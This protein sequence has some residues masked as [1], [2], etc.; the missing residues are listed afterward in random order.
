M[1][2]IKN[3]T[4]EENKKGFTRKYLRLRTLIILV[5]LLV[6][7]SYAWFIFATK[8]SGGLT[9]HVTSWNVTFQVGEDETITNVII[10][11]STIYPGME[12]YVK[13]IKVKNV[14]ESTA[15]LSYQYKSL[16]ILG[17]TYTVGENCTEEELNEK[18]ANEYPFKINVTVDKNEL[19]IA[20]GEGLYT[21]TVEWPY[22]SGDDETDTYWGEKAYEFSQNN[23][24]KSSLQ[25]SLFLIAEQK[26]SDNQ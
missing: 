3:S 7:N 17:E 21:I 11:V 24:D 6:F 22:E 9:A 2:K 5:V 1:K 14:G 25:L 23:P 16:T 18:I 19:E 13:E 8:V 20:K 15:N 4:S 10:D 26:K 12:N